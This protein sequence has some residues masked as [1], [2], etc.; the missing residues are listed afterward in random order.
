MADELNAPRAAGRALRA[1]G[2]VDRTGV[3]ARAGAIAAIPV[4]SVLAIGTAIG[5]PVGAVTVAAGAMLG[6]VAWRAGGP[7]AP[8]VGTMAAAALALA[9][10]TVTGSAS[11]RWPWLH[12]ALL[13]GVCLA[14]GIA[15]SLGRRGAVVGTQSIIA[16]VVF[17]RF[18]QPF[19]SAVALGGLVLAGGVTQTLFATLLARPP[20][21]RQQRAAVA[22]AYRRLAAL[23]AAPGTTVPAAA[24]LDAAEA[25]LTAPALLAD[26]SVMALSA[27][28]DEGRRIRLE[29]IVLRAAADRA[30]RRPDDAEATAVLDGRLA[31]LGGQVRAAARLAAASR[32]RSG[33][34]GVPAPTRGS[35]LPL[36]GL[37][38]DLRRIRASLTLESAAGRHA[39]RLAVVVA[40]TELLVQRVALP[41]AYWAVVAAATVLRPDFAATFTRGGER[42]LGTIAGVLI[43]SLIAVGLD[44]GGWGIVAVVGLLAFGTYA[45]FP[46]SFAAGTALLTAVI[47]FL[48]HAVAPASGTI[49]LDRGI[50]TAIGGAIGLAAYA[51]WP[52]WS[53]ASTGRLL[54]AVVEAQRSYLAAVLTGIVRGE[55]L[56]DAELRPLARRARMAYSDAEAAVTLAHTEPARGTDPGRAAAALAGMRRL[57]YG[58]HGL[59]VEAGAL[60]QRQPAPALAPLATG[61]AEALGQLAGRLRDES[62][63][64]GLPPLRDAYRRALPELP[65]P[66]AAAVRI[67]LD[68]L[69][70]ATDTVAA[71]LGQRV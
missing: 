17:G 32:R 43:A 36:A 6:G 44:P 55:P 58:A 11:G 46:A 41:R 60:A 31:A 29:L 34:V 35:R 40:G 71:S 69:I 48:L 61:L 19:G 49:A 33:L 37:R 38:E 3:S 26:R 57:V 5:R 14:A 16:F 13:V 12:L 53:G 22:E 66:L 23:A 20:A 28:V 54:A 27:L 21:W 7:D 24:A 9:L 25:R 42:V 68:E 10:A 65:E 1:A 50:D 39:V 51:L 70:D 67:P 62:V 30:R 52:T 45:V 47:V 63:A 8:P 15:T 4:A 2:R 59:R 18:P 56:L 64:G